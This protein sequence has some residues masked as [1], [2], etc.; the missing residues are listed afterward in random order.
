MPG[1]WLRW[2]TLREMP[3][4]SEVIILWARDDLFF[5]N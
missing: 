3:P 4:S 1:G 2:V 5:G